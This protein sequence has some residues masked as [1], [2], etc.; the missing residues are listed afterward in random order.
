MNSLNEVSKFKTYISTNVEQDIVLNLEM[1]SRKTSSE[2]VFLAIRG[3]RFNAVNF[4]EQVV[5]NKCPIIIYEDTKENNSLVEQFKNQISWIKV[6]D[7]TSFLQE[8]SRLISDKI[9]SNNG[10]VF[11]ISGSNGKTTTREMLNHLVSGICDNVITTQKNNN[12]HIGVPLTLLQATEST[13]VAIIELGSNHPGEIKVLCEASNPNY[14]VT[15]NIGHTHLE[16][17]HSLEAVFKEEA[18]LFEWMNSSS[19]SKFFLVNN[20]DEYLKPINSS[21]TKSYGESDS[22]YKFTF[23]DNKLTINYAK[24]SFNISNGYITGQHN[25]FNLGVAFVLSLQAYPERKKDLLELTK[26]FRPTFNR[27]Q[28]TQIDK[29]QIFLDAYNANPSSMLASI[30][31]FLTKI[32]ENDKALFIIGDMN[33]LGKLTQGLHKSTAREISNKSLESLVFIGQYKNHFKAGYAAENLR[34]YEDV[35]SYMSDLKNDLKSY[36]HIFIKGSRSLQ[37]ERLLD[38]T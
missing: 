11:A 27:S 1:D 6:T 38:I 22:D 30:D 18:Y 36:T 29:T 20:D 13:Q 8:F 32:N 16:F 19:D 35:Q 21:F 5:K 12:N 15:T 25:F 3:E 2:N 14:G 37:L 4:L 17:F 7:T 34:L 26:T 10:Q 23:E 28:W 31:G 33:E 24:E 9:K